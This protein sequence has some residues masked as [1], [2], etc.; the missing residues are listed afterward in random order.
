MRSSTAAALRPGTR[1]SGPRAG[2][3]TSLPEMAHGSTERV[4]IV[5]RIKTL[6]GGHRFHLTAQGDSTRFDHELEMRPQ[7]AFRLFAPM[8]GMIG[9]RNLRDTANAVQVHLEKEPTTP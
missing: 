1:R 9:R 8:M 4:R 2:S 5:P 6:E 7:G 3:T